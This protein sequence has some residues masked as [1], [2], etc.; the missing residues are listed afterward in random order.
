[1]YLYVSVIEDKC[2]VYCFENHVL[3]II[4][5]SNGNEEITLA[6]NIGLL[7]LQWKQFYILYKEC[8]I[9]YTIFY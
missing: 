1:M 8:L 6:I 3:S 2:F 7:I 5:Y 9:M 4:F